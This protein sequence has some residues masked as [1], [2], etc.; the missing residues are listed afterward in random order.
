M[1]RIH[2]MGCRFVCAWLL[3]FSVVLGSAAVIQAA[4]AKNKPPQAAGEKAAA[5]EG[6][7]SARFGMSEKQVYKSIYKDFKVTKKNVVRHRHPLEKTLSLE[8][9]VQDL[10]PD[11]GPARVFYVFGY[12]S[13]R[14][15]QVN[16]LWGKSAGAVA[17]P[18]RIVDTANQL[19]NY[20]SQ[21]GFPKKHQVANTP[22]REGLII[23]FR[24]R[25]RAGRMVLLL[26]TNPP[27]QKSGAAPL[28]LKLS[29]I[30]KPEQPDVF[31]IR[32]GQF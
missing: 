20:F 17:E 5:V 24:A 25:D 22:A 8:I 15:I 4:A 9:A 14:L 6:F 28:S 23:V 16:I 21:Q 27:K 19:R 29:Y 31:Q 32:K 1:K 11:S 30:Q 7:R 12:R 13:N 18:K 2:P 3:A 26:M 10:L